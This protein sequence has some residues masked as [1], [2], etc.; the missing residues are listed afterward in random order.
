MNVYKRLE[1]KGLVVIAMHRGPADATSI[2]MVGHQNRWPFSVY[3]GGTVKGN[4][5][6]TNPQTFI[7]DFEGNLAFDSRYE[8]DPERAVMK[9][10]AQ[11]PDWLVGR[12]MKK[13]G[14]EARDIARRRDLA[15]V[16]KTL[17][18]K[19]ASDDEETKEEAEYLLG[20]L[21]WFL[22][23]CRAKAKEKYED[24]RPS[25]CLDFLDIL[26][27]G[28]SGHPA[29]EKAKEEYEAK[30]ADDAFQ[31]ELKAER[32]ADAMEKYFYSMK[33][34][35]SGEETGRWLRK[36]A[37]YVGRIRRSWSSLQKKYADTRVYQRVQSIARELGL[38]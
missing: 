32:M 30:K 28:F 25:E 4:D 18:E 16:M 20:R 7:F 23:W 13:L 11:A 31:K 19:A 37:R 29:G 35:D 5:Q 34:R 22:E 36:N 1:R 17:E 10:A 15:E 21:R 24:G 38:D 12:H 3:N 8:T 14:S 26:S 9:V 6:N 27:G 2:A 33:P